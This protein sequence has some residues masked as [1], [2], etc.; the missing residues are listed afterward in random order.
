MQDDGMMIDDDNLYQ[1]Q[2]P[3]A[4]LVHQQVIERFTPLLRALVKR[5]GGPEIENLQKNETPVS[6]YAPK[7]Q[8]IKAP[9][10]EYTVEDCLEYLQHKERIVFTKPDPPLDRFLRDPYSGK[11]ALSG[12][13]WS[14]SAWRA[15][16]ASLRQIGETWKDDAMLEQVDMLDQYVKHEYQ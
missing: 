3:Q 13:E 4:T 5:V 2:I 7:W 8:Q 15:A 12:V 16:V 11:G 1:V 9:I 14:A 10:E 6:K